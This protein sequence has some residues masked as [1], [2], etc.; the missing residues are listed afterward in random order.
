MY[1]VHNYTY[2]YFI[3][4]SPGQAIESIH[5]LLYQIFPYGQKQPSVH[6]P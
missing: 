5:L 6:P 2:L 1:V 3:S 4:Y